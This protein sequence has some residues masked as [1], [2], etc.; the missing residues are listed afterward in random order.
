MKINEVEALSGITKKNIR[1]YEDAGLISPKR[2]AQ[3]GYREYSEEDVALLRRIRLFRKLGVPLEEI[4]QM[5]AGNYT[6][7]DGMR[8]HSITLEREQRNLEQSMQ[9][10]R[11]MQSMEVPVNQ[12]DAE[13]ILT[14][15]AL[16]E[17]SGTAFPDAQQRDIRR[18][19][20]VPGVV[21]AVTVVFM[22]G[23]CGLLVWAY[24]AEP[25]GAPPLWFLWMILGLFAAVAVGAVV[26]LVQ[27]IQEIQKGE[28]WDAKHY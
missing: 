2:N 10:C 20:V 26:A 16:L 27:R 9:M 24:R 25:E 3:N 6:V 21:T 11:Q 8:R 19:F 17:S 15:M 13:E 18:E 14:Q 1:F 4:R 12:L 22:L 28:I 23:L 5:L 7:A